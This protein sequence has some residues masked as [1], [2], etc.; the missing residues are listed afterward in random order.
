MVQE[1]R[2]ATAR[3]LLACLDIYRAY[4][5]AFAF[6]EEVPFTNNLAERGLRP[7]KSH[8]KSSGTF[9]NYNSAQG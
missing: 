6:N 9:K 2:R 1:N 4:V 7:L 5:L 8:D 3:N